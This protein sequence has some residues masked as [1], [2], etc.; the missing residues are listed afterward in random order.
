VILRL[1]ISNAQA[2]K[3][4]RAT[5]KARRKDELKTL[6]GSSAGSVGMSYQRNILN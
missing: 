5:L 2:P 3:V 6:L 4:A 1:V